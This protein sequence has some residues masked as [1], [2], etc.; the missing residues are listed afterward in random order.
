[1]RSRPPE[2]VSISDRLIKQVGELTPS[3]HQIRRVARRISP[4]TRYS[5]HTTP[6]YRLKS[7]E[8]VPPDK[9]LRKHSPK[10]A[11]AL[12]RNDH[13]ISL[14]P[15]KSKHVRHPSLPPSLPPS[16]HPLQ[17]AHSSP[18]RT[19]SP[20]AKAQ[21]SNNANAYIPAHP[22]TLAPQQ[23]NLPSTQARPSSATR[24]HSHPCTL[25]AAAG[26][27]SSRRSGDL[28]PVCVRRRE[29]GEARARCS[30]RDVGLP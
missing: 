18:R 4:T 26:S 25:R 7:A 9:S 21:H 3:H 15:P 17:H 29:E 8:H 12:A 16:I 22:E 6:S 20:R 1:M 23:S 19:P 27:R 30:D 14:P 10:P 2:P 5:H 13:P 28:R 11:T 24:T